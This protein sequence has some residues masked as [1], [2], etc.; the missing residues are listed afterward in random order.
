MTPSAAE[1][2][3]IVSAAGCSSSEQLVSARD[4]RRMLT[5]LG[6]YEFS[7]RRAAPLAKLC[8]AGADYGWR[9]LERSARR[10][11]LDQI[12]KKVRESLRR[13][14]QKTLERITRPSFELEWT[15]F[16]LA[17]SSLGLDTGLDPT[18]TERMFLRDRPS[19]R[20]LGLFGT[21]PVLAG[22]WCLTIVHWRNHVLELL[23]R[24][25]RDRRALSHFLCDKE[26]LSGIEDVRLGLS[27]SHN[28]GRSVTLIEFKKGHRVIYKPRSGRNEAIWFSLLAWMNRNGFR[29]KLRVARVLL[30]DGYYWMEYVAGASCE[31]EAAARRFYERMGGLIAAAYLLKA[32]DCHRQNVIAEG[33]YPVLVDIDALWHVSPLTKTQGATDI[34]Y[35]T[36]FFPNSRPGSLQSRS[37]VLGKASTGTHLPRL[38]GEPLGPGAYTNDIIAGF[39]RAWHCLVGTPTRRAAFRRILRR[40]RA[41]NRRWIYLATETY[42]A[43]L[44]ASIQPGLL[45]SEAAREALIVQ[46]CRPRAPTRKVAEAEIKALTELDLPY[47]VRKTSYSLPRDKSS[48]PTELTKAIRTSLAPG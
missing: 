33:E 34:L 21:F 37:S 12:A 8:S 13:H 3:E 23:Q 15:S 27:D 14:L 28:G 26:N 35:R 1:I 9:E 36:G 24:V 46:S 30:R 10:D 19:Y 5:A 6:R 29:P 31:S 41:Q 48:V 43:I 16:T 11:L 7:A 44:R 40:I 39:S 4:L 45:R 38:A 18:T 2:E 32:V 22:L 20:L 17:M 47:F 42:A 25:A